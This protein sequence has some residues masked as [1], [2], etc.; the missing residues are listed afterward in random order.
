MKK[1]LIGIALTFVIAIF[2]SYSTFA[3]M[4]GGFIPVTKNMVKLQDSAPS[5]FTKNWTLPTCPTTPSPTQPTKAITTNPST[6]KMA[7]FIKKYTPM[8]K[9]SATSKPVTCDPVTSKPVTCD[10]VTSKPVTCDPITSK[11]VTC[12]PITSKPVTCDPVTSKPVTC[13][14]VT[15]KPVTCDP[16]TSKPVTCDPVTSKPVTC[17][18][19][20]SKPV[21]CDPVTS[22]PVT[23]D[24]VTSKPVT[25]KPVTSK[26]VTS[27]PVTSEPTTQPND[28]IHQVLPI[29]QEILKLVNE[30]RA[31][32]GLN[33]LQLSSKVSSVA[34]EKSEDMR[35]GSYFGHQSPTYGSPSDML[36]QFGVSY[37]MVGENIAAGQP[38]AKAVMDGWMASEGHRANILNPDFT[39]I[40]IGYTSGGSYGS[41]WTQMFIRV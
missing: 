18:P 2:P 39:H 11:P 37:P 4:C 36:K 16:V 41:Y 26:P 20:T 7:D 32:N 34:R 27:K 17:D 5:D 25:S 12:D 15:S 22:K 24:P 8:I 13:D 28:S 14:P 9:T 1:Y 23:C 31:K 30:E 19:V 6:E 10:P 38:T 3:G 35:D 33:P 21:T 29:E 40:G